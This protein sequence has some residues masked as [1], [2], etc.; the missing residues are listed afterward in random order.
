MKEINIEIVL[1]MFFLLPIPKTLRNDKVKVEEA[2]IG[3]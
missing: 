2:K 3:P 1:S